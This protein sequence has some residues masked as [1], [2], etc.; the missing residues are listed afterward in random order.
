MRGLSCSRTD[1]WIAWI[2]GLKPKDILRSTRQG[3]LFLFLEWQTRGVRFRVQTRGT[4]DKVQTSWGENR[5]GSGDGEG[6]QG[7]AVLAFGRRL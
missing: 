3:C 7:G 4:T 6:F 5:V 2:Q 1:A